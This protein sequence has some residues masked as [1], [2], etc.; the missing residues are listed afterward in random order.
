MEQMQNKEFD[1]LFKEQLE[2]AEVTPS[3]NLWGNIA[4]QL[5][6]VRKRL[7][8]AYLTA[9]A[10]A[11]L[12]VGIGL[13]MPEGEKIRLQAPVN[14]LANIPLQAP[15]NH[16][17]NQRVTADEEPVAPATE[18][19]PLVIAPRLTEA[20]AQKDL[21]GMQ[22]G[23]DVVLLVKKPIVVATDRVDAVTQPSTEPPVSLASADIAVE[24]P[25][26]EIKEGHTEYKGIRNV[27]DLV[28]FVVSKVDKREKK[29]LRFETDDDN[30]SLVAF[31]I[32]F[33]KFNKKT[34]K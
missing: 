26:D 12:V 5:Q 18:S 25:L 30:S 4:D 17:D 31:N 21:M 16:A 33:I 34:E 19:T 7:L 13:L 29:F 22:P 27:G 15:V 20:E 32:G 2:G 6:P 23:Q 28:N 8:P 9:A 3:A 24:N 10:A 11:L 14:V 1:R